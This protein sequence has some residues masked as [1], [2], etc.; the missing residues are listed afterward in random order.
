MASIMTIEQLQ[1]RLTGLASAAE[2]ER[3]IIDHLR[4]IRTLFYGLTEE[5]VQQVKF[6]YETA[7]F[8]LVN[9]A[10]LQNR[11]VN[12]TPAVT[13]LLV[14]FLAFWERARLWTMIQETGHRLPEGPLRSKA[15]AIFRYKYITDARVQY[16]D[17]LESILDLLNPVWIVAEDAGKRS[18]VEIITEYFLDAR[19]NSG[20]LGP[21][22][23]SNLASRMGSEDLRLKYA[24]LLAVR[25]DPFLEMS[26]DEL[27]ERQASA[28]MVIVESLHDEAC[29]I[30][31]QPVI[32]Q[33]DDELPALAAAQ[34][35][36]R[37]PAEL[38]ALIIGMDARF[39]QLRHGVG[40]NWD[41]SEDRNRIYLGTYLPR[42]IIEAWNILSELLSQSEILRAFR[43]KDRIR[44]L[45]IG[46]GTGGAVIGTLLALRDAGHTGAPIDIHSWDANTDAL[47]K[48]GTLLD[49][50]A[51]TLPF[52]IQLHTD[53]V[54]LPQHTPFYST[55]LRD[56]IE[57]EDGAYD[58]ILCWK[59]LCEFYNN[60]YLL[61]LGTVK[62]TIQ[63]VSRALA[64]NSIFI[65]TDITAKDNNHEWF[66]IILNRESQQYLREHTGSLRT[67]LPIPCAK[68][69]DQCD[70]YRCFT[71]RQLNV[72]HA[73]RAADT[74][75]IAYRVFAP[76]HFADRIV[77]EYA[78]HARYRVNAR[79]P[80][81]HCVVDSTAVAA[82][83][84]CGYTAM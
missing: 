77:Q 63:E 16:I 64:P 34:R 62:S 35:Q 46:S 27:G 44:I 45:D 29:S 84:A 65:V 57:A 58:I 19:V 12:E 56:R 51:P 36:S 23:A 22:I 25:V 72:S 37:L 81:E 39:E 30:L 55:A 80:H 54:M 33:A 24:I 61:A 17:R 15:L 41:A 83:P 74:T 42:T 76:T 69:H 71:Q 31:P 14:F 52:P 28:R 20:E 82:E 43:A 11:L 32:E 47:L 67:I 4:E 73:L 8:R 59:Y 6:D 70:A 40:K 13:A 10:A 21:T 75:R 38:D 60:S 3:Y 18:C 50:I 78:G 7:F 5:E 53:T 9:T 48:Q 79:A 66:P 1:T 49:G 2:W 68:R 26:R